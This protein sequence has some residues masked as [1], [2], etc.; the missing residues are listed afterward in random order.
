MNVKT[1]RPPAPA[2][3]STTSNANGKSSAVAGILD[4]GVVAWA[5]AAVAAGSDDGA[6]AVSG[7]G[8]GE[9]GGFF[10]SDPVSGFDISFP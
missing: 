9:A 10:S 8:S 3:H 5:G 6:D 2:A 4:W 7:A 1:A